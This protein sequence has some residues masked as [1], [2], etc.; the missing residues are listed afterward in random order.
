MDESHA[1]AVFWI[2]QIFDITNDKDDIVS[3]I[4]KIKNL[5]KE[6]IQEELYR[7]GIYESY[8]EALNYSQNL[9]TEDVKK[10][11]EKFCFEAWVILN[12]DFVRC[13]LTL[14]ALPAMQLKWV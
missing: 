14:E 7:N 11:I 3:N 12:R 9:L 6:K 8:L 2:N 13:I 10:E 1:A 5:S 4:E